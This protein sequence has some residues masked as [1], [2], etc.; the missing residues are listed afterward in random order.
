VNG[1][2][3]ATSGRRVAVAWFTGAA[4]TQQVK[5]AFSNDSGESFGEP[6]KV[7]DGSPAGRVDVLLLDDGSAM[8]CWLEKLPGGGEVRARRVWPNG[9]RDQAITVAASG[10]ARS[11]GFPQM[12]LAGNTLVFAWTGSRV[13]TATMPVEALK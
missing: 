8:V 7:D 13:L 9:R 12:A 5:L 4:N 11:N 2:A 1:P 3:V 6:V 10:T